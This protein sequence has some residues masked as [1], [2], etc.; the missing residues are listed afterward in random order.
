M[1]KKKNHEANKTNLS[2]IPE[3]PSNY[4]PIFLLPFLFQKQSCYSCLFYL[5][6]VLTNPPKWLIQVAYSTFKDYFLALLLPPCFWCQV[7]RFHQNLQCKMYSH[8]QSTQGLSPST[9]KARTSTLHTHS[10]SRRSITKKIQCGVYL[11]K[12]HCSVNVPTRFQSVLKSLLVL[13]AVRTAISYSSNPTGSR[14]VNNPFN[15]IF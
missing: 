1:E 10:V 9:P 8:Q 15:N 7:N 3:S 6:S 2:L 12:G 11:P 4:R 13:T 5:A 14:S